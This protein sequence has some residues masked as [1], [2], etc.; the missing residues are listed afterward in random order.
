MGVTVPTSAYL[1]IPFCRRRCFY[2]D[3]PIRVVGDQ[4]HGGNSPAIARYVDAICEE[5]RLIKHSNSS[6]A[7][8]LSPNLGGRGA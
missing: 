6:T 7:Q 3:F 5:I 1:H 2:C 8:P 4:R